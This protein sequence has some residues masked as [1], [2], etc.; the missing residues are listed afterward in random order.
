MKIWLK[1][2][3]EILAKIF[4]YIIII[5]F[6][7]F[8]ASGLKNMF[9]SVAF[10]N[11]IQVSNAKELSMSGEKYLRT[12]CSYK[13]KYE[14]LCEKYA[15]IRLGCADAANIDTCIDIRMQVSDYEMCNADGSLILLGISNQNQMP[16]SFQCFIEMGL[17]Y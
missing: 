13:S 4:E 16:T 11:D 12:Y 9:V 1:I 14:N 10:L 2:I 5:I 3:K 7:Y 15:K 17:F 8:V 6:L